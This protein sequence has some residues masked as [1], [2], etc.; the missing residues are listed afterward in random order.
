MGCSVFRGT[1]WAF[2]R[3]NHISA[4]DQHTQEEA[5]R[6]GGDALAALL[7]DADEVILSENDGVQNISAAFD[8]TKGQILPQ[9][10]SRSET[11]IFA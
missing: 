10:A 2:F 1:E 3:R 11:S 6:G 9:K 4:D 7:A 5:E 8:L